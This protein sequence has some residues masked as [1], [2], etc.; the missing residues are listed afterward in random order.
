MEWGGD[1]G[2]GGE[3][4]GRG[5]LIIYSTIFAYART[6]PE[7]FFAEWNLRGLTTMGAHQLAG[8]CS[9]LSRFVNILLM[10]R[11]GPG[12]EPQPGHF[13]LLF[14]APQRVCGRFCFLGWDWDLEF[15]EL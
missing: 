7:L 15:G 10:F 13:F 5:G 1:A 14:S 12:I 2:V 11:K 9:W 6:T 8:W 4:V 3:A